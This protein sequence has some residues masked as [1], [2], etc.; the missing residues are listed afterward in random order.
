M[1]GEG[2]AGATPTSSNGGTTGGNDGNGGMGG[3]A[4]TACF[5]DAIDI[6]TALVAG[7]ITV[8][9]GTISANYGNVA[10]SNGDDTVTLGATDSGT[11]SVRAVPGTYEAI[12]VGKLNGTHPLGTSVTIAPSGTTTFD[13]DVPA[14]TT[15][16]P[17]GYMEATGPEHTLSGHVRL[18]GQPALASS[19]SGLTLFQRPAGFS[20]TYAWERFT[21]VDTQGTYRGPIVAGTYDISGMDLDG[22]ASTEA[23]FPLNYMPVLVA[24]LVIDEDVDL[25][26]DIPSTTVAGTVALN[27]EDGTNTNVVLSSPTLGSATLHAFGSPPDFSAHVIPGTYDVLFVRGGTG[28]QNTQAVLRSGVEVSTGGDT[29]IDIDVQSVDISGHFTLDGATVTE[30]TQSGTIS[31]A[32]ADGDRIELGTTAS[33]SYATT[34]MPGTYDIYY[35]VDVPLQASLAPL[36]TLGKVRSGIVIAAGAPMTLDIDVVTTVISGTLEIDGQTVD[37]ES[38]GGRIWLRTDDGDEL[39]L[40]WTSTGEFSARVLPGAYDVVYEGTAASDRAPRNTAAKLGCM[41]VEAGL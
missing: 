9:G 32:T 10:L 11:Y 21:Q 31:L 23:A 25:D 2:G 30:K 7:T 39:P 14:A 34:V 18:N 5:T 3:T 38:D 41:H 4:P 12:Y 17:G 33:G 22:A 13:I 27:G 29:R 6:P 15:T 8:A 28:P 26:I 1:T 16:A 40:G 36:N 24:G 37:L 19:Y 35:S 20:K